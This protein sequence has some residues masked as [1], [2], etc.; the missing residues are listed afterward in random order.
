MLRSELC[1]YSN[2]YI[3]VKGKISDADTDNDNEIKK[4]TFKNKAPD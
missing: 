2:A 3:V 4:L 1:D